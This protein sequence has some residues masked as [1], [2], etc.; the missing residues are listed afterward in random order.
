MQQSTATAEQWID[1]NA[2]PLTGLDADAPLTDLEPLIEAVGDAVVVGL[3]ETTRASR[4][5]FAIRMRI[6]RLLVERL[7]FRGLAIQDDQGIVAGLDEYVRTGEG[8]PRRL[9]SEVWAPWRTEETA[10]ALEWVRAF[11]ASNPDDPIHVFGVSP[12]KARLFDYDAVADYV[13]RVAPRRLDELES[14]YGVIRT[15]HDVGEHVQRFNGTHPGR[16]FVE[17]ARDAVDLIASLPDGDGKAGALRHARTIVEFHGSSIAASTGF[18]S[19]ARFASDAILQWRRDTG[20]KVAYW[21][22]VAFVAGGGP[23]EVKIAK[24]ERSHGAGS[25]LRRHLGEGYLSVLLT[26]HHGLL[27]GG[28]EVPVPPSDYVETT[29]DRAN[30]DAY[31][32]D[33]RAPAPS[34][35]TEWLADAHKTRVVP[36]IYDPAEDAEHHVVASRFSEWFDALVYVRE[37]TPTRMLS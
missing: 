13:R 22:G 5:L 18:D 31:C 7:D 37:I 36:G 27:H 20:G 15:A 1:A 35:V 25:L 29:L 6:F 30:F 14:C 8:D 32:L 26:F 9:L 4:E 28:V 33:L 21:D 19:S 34:D 23:F 3:G 12:A 10:Q 11:N 2:H 24:G 16:P 17:H